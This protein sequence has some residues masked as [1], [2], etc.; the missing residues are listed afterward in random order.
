VQLGVLAFGSACGAVL[1]LV[2]GGRKDSLAGAVFGL[3]AAIFCCP[4]VPQFLISP[5]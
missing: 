1:G 3:M 4:F 2:T 5:P